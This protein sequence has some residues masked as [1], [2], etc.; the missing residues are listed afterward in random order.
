MKYVII[1]GGGITGLSAA[2]YLKQQADREGLSLSV[3][4]L[5]KKSRLGGIIETEK[6]NGFLLERGPD[7]FITEKPW[8]CELIRSLGIEDQ[9]ASTNTQARG[10]MV[11]R[12]GRLEKVPEGFYLLAPSRTAA[13][14]LSNI[15]SLPGKMRTLAELFIS[16]RH[17]TGDE[18]AGAFIR[19]RFGKEL[20]ERIGQAMIGGI[21]SADPDKLSMEAALPRFREME[22]K[23][24]S[25]ICALHNRHRNDAEKHAA[26]PRYGL[27]VSMKEGL[28]DLV[29]KLS[30]SLESVTIKKNS[31]VKSLRRDGLWKVILEDGQRLEAD[32]VILALPSWASA[33]ALEEHQPMLAKDLSR[34]PYESAVTVNLCFN[35]AALPQRYM[36][37]GYVVPSVE[38]RPL[39]GCTISSLKFPKRAP[40]GGLLLRAFVGGSKHRALLDKGDDEILEIVENDVIATLGIKNKADIRLLSRYSDA[41]PQYELGHCS[42]V[43][44]IFL[45]AKET[46]GLFLAGNAYEGIGL[47]DCVKAGRD[48]ASEVLHYLFSALRP[49]NPSAA[50]FSER[51]DL[52]R[53]AF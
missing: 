42:L 52:S 5:E 4:L 15:M 38:Q 49:E 47:P 17:E 6:S 33:A 39:L 34:I 36:A 13:F 30:Q 21:Y 37:F 23:Y 25:V 46:P 51:E 27:F 48:R 3:T 53:A 19:R 1:A 28:Q 2:Y 41:M 44:R 50:S 31:S 16:P 20:Y 18:S 29:E 22:L 7:S 10:S 8:A 45:R 40:A 9:L 43:R 14:L 26:G 32:A 24:G 35:S 12:A 11:L